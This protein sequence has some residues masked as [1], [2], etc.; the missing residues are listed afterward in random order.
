MSENKPTPSPQV[1]ADKWSEMTVSELY[2]QKGI[3]DGRLVAAAQ[4]GN[5]N[6]L[7]QVQMGINAINELITQK[8]SSDTRLI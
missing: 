5:A 7:R 3:L 4:L 2:E 6:L 1:R 8:A